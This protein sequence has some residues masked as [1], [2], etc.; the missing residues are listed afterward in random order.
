MMVAI[1]AM[2]PTS[3]IA[4]LLAL[5]SAGIVNGNSC[6]CRSFVE[7]NVI[8]KYRGF[9]ADAVATDTIKRIRIKKQM[10]CLD[11]N[12]T[13]K[14]P[15]ELGIFRRNYTH[16]VYFGAIATRLFD[17]DDTQRAWHCTGWF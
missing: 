16:N 5:V 8:S 2:P 15:N 7:T 6:R 1:L 12:F 9:S 10:L 4:G 17:Y 14:F 13:S 11:F 3:G